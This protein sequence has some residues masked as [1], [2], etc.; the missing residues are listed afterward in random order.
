MKAPC[1]HLKWSRIVCNTNTRTT[2]FLLNQYLFQKAF[3]IF[4]FGQVM[5]V[6]TSETPDPPR[7]CAHSFASP[8]I[9]LRRSICGYQESFRYAS[10][11]S[12]QQASHLLTRYESSTTAV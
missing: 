1:F 7:S 12:L 2:A 9:K 3:V 5:C 8:R 10:A 6:A 11:F 4:R